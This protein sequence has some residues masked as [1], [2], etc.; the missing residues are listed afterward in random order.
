M[1]PRHFLLAAAFAV[2]AAAPAQVDPSIGSVMSEVRQEQSREQ[3]DAHEEHRKAQARAEAEAI[4]DAD[5]A[6]IVAGAKVYD[7]D[8]GLIGAIESV[9]AQGAVLATGA[10]KA[11]VP[12]AS[13]GKNRRGLTIGMTRAEFEAAATAGSS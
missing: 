9:D 1:K 8:G 6:D 12:V 5:L 4:V 2:P 3:A 7:N 13:F 11:R 10:A